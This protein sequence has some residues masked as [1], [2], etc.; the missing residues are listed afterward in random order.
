MR[1]RLI[2][3]G[4]AV[5]HSMA[6][7]YRSYFGAKIYSTHAKHGAHFTFLFYDAATA[8]PL[9]QF[10]ANYLGQIRTGAASGLA[11]DVLAPRSGI[12][13]GIIGAGFQARTQLEA[14]ATVR[15][16]VEARVWSRNGASRSAFAEEMSRQ[17]GVAVT[18]ASSAN[19]ACSAADVVVTATYAKDPV[20]D[21]GAVRRDALVIAVGSNNP[22]RRELPSDLVQNASIV[23]DDLDACRIEAGDLLLGLPDAAWASVIE[24]KDVVAGNTKAGQSDRL[25]VFKSVGL[26]LEDVAAAAAVYERATLEPTPVGPSLATR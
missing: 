20:I 2:L 12:A 6:G 3:P 1:R 5:L 4:G 19:D 11:A 7:A 10:E 14:L 8:A 25:T 24:L 22:Q 15:R 9:A 16:I 21:F 26:G 17:L 18:P 23:V 13:V